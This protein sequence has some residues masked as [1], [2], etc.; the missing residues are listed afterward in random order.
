MK[1]IITLLIALS[2]TVLFIVSC[3]GNKEAQGNSITVMVPDWAVPSDEMLNA[4]TKETGITVNMN[5]MAWE[6]IRDKISIAAAGGTAAADVVEV[7]WS[8]VGEFYSADWLEPI[9]LTQEEIDA[10]PSIQPFIIDGKVLALPYANDFRLAYYNKKHF[11]TAGITEAPKSWDNVYEDLKKIKAAGVTKYPFSMPLNAD[12]SCT[13]SLIWL[14]YSKYGIVFNEDGTLNKDAVL[15]ALQFINQMVNVDN[16]I[17]PACKTSTGMD[18]YRRINSGEASFIVGPTSFVSRVQDTN[19]SQVVGD[20]I[21]ILLPGATG[22]SPKTFALPEGVGVIKLSKN[23]EAAMKFVKWFNSPE[24]QKQLNYV[25]N[26]MPTRTSVM[27]ELINEGKL[28]NTGALLEESKLISSPFPKGVPS[29]YSEMTT[30]IFNAVNE[31]VLGAK[32]PEQA[33]DA[34]DAKIKELA[35]R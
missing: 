35:A 21:P 30:A 4:F 22:P 31:M 17:D 2:L 20:V 12:E 7:D 28:K 16:L 15:G 32:T 19:E 1:K 25:Q 26:T 13:T 23:K 5:A 3:N 10:M 14:T 6:N 33:F 29:Y 34:M 8:W 27:E 24:I 18:A 9:E 11:E